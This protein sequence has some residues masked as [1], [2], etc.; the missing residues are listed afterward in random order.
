MVKE[1]TDNF[2]TS[3]TNEVAQVDGRM[4]L[5]FETVK[6]NVQL[7][8]TS[9]IVHKADDTITSYMNNSQGKRQHLQRTAVLKPKFIK[10]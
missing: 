2:V 4:S 9:P 10:N 8:A 6:E 1:I 7:L 5:Y 3:T